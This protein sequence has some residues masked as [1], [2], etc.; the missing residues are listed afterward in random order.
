[1]LVW[2][3]NGV[4]VNPEFSP[5]DFTLTTVSTSPTPLS[6]TSFSGWIFISK[7]NAQ[8]GKFELHFYN[9]RQLF[10]TVCNFHTP[11]KLGSLRYRF[12]PS[13]RSDCDSIV[14]V[15]LVCFSFPFNPKLFKIFLIIS[16]RFDPGQVEGRTSLGFFFVYQLL[17]QV[18]IEF[19]VNSL[20]GRVLFSVS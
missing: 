1:M 18:N 2:S 14:D 13:R 3:E 16:F 7:F 20:Q 4:Q 5:M 19:L 15:F 8:Q 9:K 12:L 11:T 10:E 17:I 6:R